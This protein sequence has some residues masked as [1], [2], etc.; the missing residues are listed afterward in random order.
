[1]SE[2]TLN[3]ILITAVGDT[4]CN[5][6]AKLTFQNIV[7][8]NPDLNLFLGD[9]SY[10]KDAICFIDIIKS[11]NGLKEKTIF[12]IGN[13]D[14][15]EDGSDTVKEQLESYFAITDWTI[16]KQVGNLYIINMDSQDPDWDLKNKDQYN[17]VKAKLE[18]ATRLR[19]V[20]KTIDWVIVMVHKPLYTLK[21]G[22][23]PE[24]KARDIYQP[25]FDQYQ[26]DLVLHGHS[27]N[28][29]R[30]L[31]IKYG[32]LDNEPIVTA[33]DLDFSQDHG[34]IYIVNGAGGREHRQFTEPKNRWTP[35]IY[36]KGFGYNLF[37]VQGKKMDI[38][39]KSNDGK[40]LDH[41]KIEK[42]NL[43]T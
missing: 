4:A 39:A 23:T 14:D 40:V 36:D 28:I 8:E 22:H 42:K 33:L 2:T 38:F 10:E 9:S 32:G 30:T 17:G 7:N 34:Q 12:S 35:F 6:D 5:D 18:E 21:G 13:H 15:K 16:I 31:P 11:H 29:Q 19:D 1:M 43:G 25:L 24:R 20:E 37:V 27:H 26:V 3:R 41:I